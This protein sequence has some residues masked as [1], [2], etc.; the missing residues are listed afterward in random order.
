MLD[1]SEVN[2]SYCKN[3]EYKIC[4]VEEKKNKKENGRTILRIGALL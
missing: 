3:Y 1:D 2:S 4:C